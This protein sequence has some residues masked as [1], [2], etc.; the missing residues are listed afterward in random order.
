MRVHEELTADGAALSYPALTAFCRRQ[1][2]GQTPIRARGPVSLRAG[3]GNAAR[4]VS[5]RSRSGRQEVPGADGL[6]AATGAV[7]FPGSVL[8]TRAAN[9]ELFPGGNGWWPMLMRVYP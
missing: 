4:Y 9:A 5:A 6:D 7:D 3:R 2:I 1:G 8:F